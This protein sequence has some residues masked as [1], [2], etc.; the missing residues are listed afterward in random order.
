MIGRV[1]LSFTLSYQSLCSNMSINTTG[2]PP[3]VATFIE[4]FYALSDNKERNDEYIDQFDWDCEAYFRIGNMMPAVTPEGIFQ[5]RRGA[6]KDVKTRKHTVFGVY[7]SAMEGK[8][9][10][11]L[12]GRVDYGKEDETKEGATWAGRMVLKRPSMISSKPKLTSYQV[13]I[14]S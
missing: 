11:M 13:W 4:Q 14:V 1:T 6:W 5:W 3:S 9:E 8:D 7:R 10:Y 12:H 2:C